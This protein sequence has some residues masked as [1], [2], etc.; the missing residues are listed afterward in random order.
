[1][2]SEFP[3][4]R[5]I[6]RNR[7]Y[8]LTP[9]LDG[10]APDLEQLEGATQWIADHI[11]KDKVYVHCAFGHSRSA[12]VVAAYLLHIGVVKTPEEAIA[13]LKKKRRGVSLMPSQRQVLEQFAAKRV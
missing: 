13:L 1:M 9:L 10:T 7:A 12:T 6:V 8:L 4:P 11:S 5:S 3:E 2:T